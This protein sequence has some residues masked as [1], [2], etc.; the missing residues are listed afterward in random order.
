MNDIFVKVRPLRE[1]QLNE[2]FLSTLTRAE[3][4]QAVYDE[5]TSIA[6]IS[7]AG[8][9]SDLKK[10]S[11]EFRSFWISNRYIILIDFLF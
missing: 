3:R 5:L 1:K 2:K 6:R 4:R 9:I 8:L 11:V 7:Q 10:T